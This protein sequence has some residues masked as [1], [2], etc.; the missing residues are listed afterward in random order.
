MWIYN[1]MQFISLNNAEFSVSLLQ[2]SVSHDGKKIIIN[3][4]IHQGCIKLI[5][6]A[7]KDIYNVR[8]Y[9]YFK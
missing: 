9:L 8:K 6:S 5:K 4:C 3:I 7:S 2:S 1:N